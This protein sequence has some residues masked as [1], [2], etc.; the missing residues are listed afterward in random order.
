MS[1]SQFLAGAIPQVLPAEICLACKVCC[2]FPD[3]ESPL[4]PVVVDGERATLELRESRCQFRGFADSRG[5]RVEPIP[6][7]EAFLCPFY[8][9]GTGECGVYADRPIDCRL[10][11]FTLTETPD[12][13]AAVLGIDRTCPAIGRG[14]YADA[15]R[16]EAEGLARLLEDEATPLLTAHHRLVGRWYPE[17]EPLVRLPG[18]S[19]ALRRTG[20]LGGTSAPPIAPP[21]LP[22][23]PD[24]AR[25][26]PGDS[27]FLERFQ[28]ARERYSPRRLGQATLPALLPH[29]AHLAIGWVE[30]EDALAV[31]AANGLAAFL[32]F[33]P[34]GP[35]PERA[36]RAV[37]SSLAR[38]GSSGEAARVEGLSE[39]EAEVFRKAGWN[40]ASR[41]PEYVY[42]R[43]DLA[44]L[45]GPEFA[46]RRRQVRVAR[47][48][49]A[50]E[51]RRYSLA[52]REACEGLLERWIAHRKQS[53]EDSAYRGLLAHAAS[54]HARAL[55][56]PDAYGLEGWVLLTRDRIAAYTFAF[57]SGPDTLC[58]LFEVADPET[59]GAG[60]LIFQ[61][62]CARTDALCTVNTLDDGGFPSLAWSKASYRPIRLEPVY[63]ACSVEKAHRG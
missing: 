59:P 50:P 56:G 61:D 16:R 20:R 25:I 60:A 10:Y 35:D 38:G 9:P 39:P 44:A 63:A 37:L 29:A 17:I 3:R 14:G 48:R 41:P 24:L 4:A 21:P 5:A 58:I 32:P 27:K 43:S 46:S 26:R 57:Q 33:A 42:R 12:G 47:R 23:M 13:G 11:P 19:R 45:A 6:E 34:L 28:R 22:R 1:D 15:F 30:V 53:H 8:V 55:S 51:V 31:V 2:H 7:R 18:L 52:D 49:L 54:A 62:L 36:A 40:L